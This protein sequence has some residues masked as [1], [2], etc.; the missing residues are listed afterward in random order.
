MCA[1]QRPR[2]SERRRLPRRRGVAALA[3]RRKR[4]VAG[5]RARVVIVSVAAHALLRRPLV[6]G[7][8]T[9]VARR[10]R[11]ARMHPVERP[12][13][14]DGR[15]LPSSDGV[16]AL[17]GRRKQIVS[18]V[19]ARVVVV[20]VAAHAFF[21]CPLVHRRIADVTRRARRVGVWP[22][23]GPLVCE[24]RR[25]PRVLAVA[26]DAGVGEHVDVG[27]MARGLVLGLMA[28]HALA[29]D[30]LAMSTGVPADP[31]TGPGNGAER[32]GEHERSAPATAGGWKGADQGGPRESER[33]SRD[34]PTS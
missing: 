13:M 1:R 23:E 14:I 9:D 24:A 20:P 10:A 34:P 12:G 8:I 26:S 16:T 18:R 7:R 15:R 29:R 2:M 25:G 28:G 11:A 32:H 27:G 6:H 4:A 22:L 19:R 5:E 17:A 33:G 31:F 21:R 3:G 30:H